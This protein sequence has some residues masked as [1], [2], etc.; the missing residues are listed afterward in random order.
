LIAFS[1]ATH[2]ATFAVL[3]ALLAAGALAAIFVP[4]I[5]PARGLIRGGAAVALGAAMLMTTNFAL[6]GRFAWTPGGYGIAFG[7]MLEDGIIA[8]YLREHCPQPDLKL[9]AHRDE[10]PATADEFLWGES[11]FNR[12]G[13]FTGLGDEMGRIVL[14]SLAEYPWM[15]F[16]TAA[17]ATLRQLTLNATGYGVH[18]KLW[19]TYG[20]IERFLPAQVPAMRA[21]R[22]QKGDLD[23]MLV[24][25]LHVPVAL[26]S[27]VLVLAV[28]GQALWR[29]QADDLALLATTAALAVLAN[30]FA[31]GALSGPHDRYGS[32]MVWITTFV[33]V[34]AI[35]RVARSTERRP[36]AHDHAP[37]DRATPASL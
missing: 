17:R 26:G 19:H 6:S 4:A 20:I 2:S 9:C 30:A 25:R 29:R 35:M 32:R 34:L 14:H 8:R 18:D 15:Q 5:V 23:L 22:Q 31:C 27:M 1:T 37:G 13:R 11:V 3:L 7:R 21:A 24:N 36:S 16:E 12:L 28:M 10:L 33:V